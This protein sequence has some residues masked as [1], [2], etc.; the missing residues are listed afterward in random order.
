MVSC[1][2]SMVYN[3]EKEEAKRTIGSRIAAYYRRNRVMPV[4]GRRLHNNG[5]S[6]DT[7]SVLRDGRND[8]NKTGKNSR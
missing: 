7:S 1:R 2:A 6:E 4:E 5:L 3:D 8:G